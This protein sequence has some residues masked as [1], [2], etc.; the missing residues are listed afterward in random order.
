M[1]DDW[2]SRL[3]GFNE[4]PYSTTRELLEVNG[5]LHCNQFLIPCILTA[6]E[7]GHDRFVDW[8]ARLQ[9]SNTHGP[10]GI[11]E[12]SRE[13]LGSGFLQAP[14]AQ[15]NGCHAHLLH[16]RGH[17]PRQEKRYG[18]GEPGQSRRRRRQG[19]SFS[20]AGFTTIPFPSG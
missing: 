8:C 10:L 9:M 5:S 13:G 20:I 7:D 4:G 18:A 3:T 6:F 16:A 15:L 14:N 11:G 19:Y 2:F 17:R 1:R 12:G